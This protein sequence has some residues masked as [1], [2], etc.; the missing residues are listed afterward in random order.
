[1]GP[2][3]STLMN[4]TQILM[5]T[6]RTP[7]CYRIAISMSTGQVHTAERWIIMLDIVYSLEQ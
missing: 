1:M 2:F 7:L 3:S 5:Y 6:D 4:P